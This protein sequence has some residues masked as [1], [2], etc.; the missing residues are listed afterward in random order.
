MAKKNIDRSGAVVTRSEARIM[1]LRKFYSGKPCP[2][3][4]LCDRYTGDGRCIECSIIKN[5]KYRAEH[6]DKHRQA[7]KS[8]RLS[9]PDRK[10]FHAATYRERNRETIRLRQS[11]YRI[12]NPDKIRESV[13]AW[14][15][16]NAEYARGRASQ[17][18]KNN[19][20]SVNAAAARRKAI[21]LG[22]LEHHTG[23][24]LASLLKKQNGKCANCRVS[25][26]NGKHADHIMPLSRG[27]SNGIKNIQFLCPPC[28]LR[29]SAKDP[30]VWA[31]Q[32]GR[33]I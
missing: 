20:E 3:G 16:E 18:S 28:N 30:V 15:Q 23:S 13:S 29:K 25:L 14:Y 2:I 1:G 7:S 17:W 31:L 8:W 27:G 5:S 26:K 12:A 21:K 33:L 6:V 11:A 32:Q 22:S 10:N 9:N 4:H 24:D 19:P